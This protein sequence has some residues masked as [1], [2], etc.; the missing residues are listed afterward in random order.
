M[1]LE[2]LWADRRGGTRL[3]IATGT[4]APTMGPEPEGVPLVWLYIALNRT[5]NID[6]YWVGAVPNL[7]PRVWGGVPFKFFRKEDGIGQKCNLQLESNVP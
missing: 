2:S 4:V 3:G 1:P 7:N 6:C 5:P